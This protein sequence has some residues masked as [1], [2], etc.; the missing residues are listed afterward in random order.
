MQLDF[1]SFRK[2]VSQASVIGLTAP[3][4]A[5]GDSAGTQAAMRELLL[6][7]FPDK[8]IR[9]INEEP[10]PV[11]Y[12]C[13]PESE[14]FEVSQAILQEPREFWPDCMICVDGGANRI[15]DDTQK[16][17]QAAKTRGQVD[18]HVIGGSDPYDFRLYDPKAAAT[19]EIVYRLVQHEKLTLT[20]NIAQA[21]YVGLVFDTG[22]F[23]HSNTKPETL[24]IAAELLAVGFDH[25]QTIEEAML[26]R[27]EAAVKMLRAVLSSAEFHVGGRY[28][29]GVLDNETLRTT[30]GTPDDRE[31]IIDAL[32][33]IRGC[34]IAA[35]LFEKDP[36]FWKVSFRSRGAW[37]VAQLAKSLNPEGGGHR[38][39]AGC[40]LE[41]ARKDV[42][43]KCN[44]AIKKLLQSN[45]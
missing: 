12:N 26:I 44:D 14:N 33:L 20:R 36:G 31:G 5:D 42:S 45:R 38:Q 30:Q 13:L 1:A 39:A 7:M 40:S 10:C 37:D 35:F 3:A 34:E 23:K 15:G 43:E 19:T 18:H 4:G 41:G 11:R 16:L 2:Y 8:Q 29:S 22:L 25:T 24:R 6:Q 9:I 27:S 21:I 17:W 32:F 28:V